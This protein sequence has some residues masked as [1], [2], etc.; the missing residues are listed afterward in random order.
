[1]SELTKFANLIKNASTLKASERTELAAAIQAAAP[2]LGIGDLKILNKAL[3]DLVAAD[4]AKNTKKA[5]R[6]QRLQ[7]ATQSEDMAVESSINHVRGELR[8][9]GFGAD[10]N[11]HAANGID[12][13]EIHK[14]AKAEGWQ[15][16][17]IINLKIQAERIGLME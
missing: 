12:A 15:P 10:I 3:S 9:L 1:M 11:A 14:R 2:S 5:Q 16:Q 7:A 17:R 13:L 6:L 8:R 4:A